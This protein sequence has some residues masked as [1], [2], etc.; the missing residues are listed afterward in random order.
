[1]MPGRMLSGKRQFVIENPTAA[2]TNEFKSDEKESQ[3]LDHPNHRAGSPSDGHISGWRGNTRS[4]KTSKIQLFDGKKKKKKNQ[5]D[6][7][8]PHRGRRHSH[9]SPALLRATAQKEGG[10]KNEIFGRS[11]EFRGLIIPEITKIK[12]LPHTINHRH[13]TQHFSRA[14]DTRRVILNP[15]DE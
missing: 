1:M 4:Q 8:P 13:P 3:L 15:P 5:K 14:K 9:T 7:S 2:R 10:V 6:A 11:F 12:D